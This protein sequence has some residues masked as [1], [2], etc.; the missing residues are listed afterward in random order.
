MAEIASTSLSPMQGSRKRRPRSRILISSSRST[1]ARRSFSC[2][3]SF[4]SCRRKQHRFP[5]VARG[6]RRR[7]H[8]PSVCGNQGRHRHFG[9]AFR[10]DARR[11]R[12]PRQCRGARWSRPTCRPSQRPTRAGIS[13]WA[14]RRSSVLR[15]PTTSAGKLIVG[16]D[17]PW[18]NVRPHRKSLHSWMLLSELRT[19]IHVDGTAGDPPGIFEKVTSF[20]RLIAHFA[21]IALM[22][23]GAW[24]LLLGTL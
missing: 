9:E 21:G 16:E 10:L 24:L 23:A 5:L 1:S 2:S 12:Y 6:A 4:R 15:S 22:A 18:N 19:T 3:N 14:C 8:D 20:G 13:R 11:T 7:G 17:S